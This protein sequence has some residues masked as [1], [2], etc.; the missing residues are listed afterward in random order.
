MYE[1]TDILEVHF[2]DV[3]Q[4]DAQLISIGNHYMLID[5]GTPEASQIIFA[6]LREH[7]VDHLDYIINTH[8]DSDH[9][10]GLPAAV[11]YV[12]GKIGTAISPYTECAKDRFTIY[13]DRLKSYGIEFTIPHTG[14]IYKLGSAEFQILNAGEG[15]CSNDR[16][17]VI[18]LTYGK[19]SFLFTGDAD[20]KDES[21]ILDKGFDIGSSVL[22]VGHHGSKTSTG[23]MFLE[24]VHP[25]YA[26]ISCGAKNQYGH[27]NE[28]V[29]QRLENANVT[30][31]RTD[32]NGHIMFTSDGNNLRAFGQKVT[33][34]INPTPYQ[35]ATPTEI[36]SYVPSSVVSQTNSTSSGSTGITSGN[37]TE[38]NVHLISY[39][40]NHNSMKFHYPWCNAAS[41]ISPKNREDVQDTREHIITMGFVPCK[42]CN[43]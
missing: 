42:I 2:I 20:T 21:T 33:P 40:L 14:D 16:S 1:K 9:V 38:N 19:T 31:F 22:K 27:P 29:L 35:K 13:A 4:A 28:E 12:D 3:G 10:G 26:V 39:V 36:S 7:N 32:V 8:S 30:I 17:I 43:P 23:A 11:I 6:Y 5:G 41:R 25:A 37:E 15:T 24:A 34:K 18:R